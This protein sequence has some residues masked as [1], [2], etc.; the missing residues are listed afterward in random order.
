MESRKSYGQKVTKENLQTVIGN[1]GVVIHS[2]P[3][4]GE[5]KTLKSKMPSSRSRSKQGHM[6]S[7]QSKKDGG[8][9]GELRSD[10]G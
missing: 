6:L 5:I 4:G 3:R 2:K 7:T 1:E 10:G 9:D 8:S